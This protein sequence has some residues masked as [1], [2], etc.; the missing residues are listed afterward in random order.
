VGLPAGVYSPIVANVEP[1][2]LRFPDGLSLAMPNLLGLEPGTRLPLYRYGNDIAGWEVVGTASVDATGTRIITDGTLLTAFSYLFAGVQ[3]QATPHTITGRVVEVTSHAVV[4]EDTAAP[5][6][7]EM[8]GVFRSLA[9]EYESVMAPIIREYFGNPMAYDHRLDGDG[10]FVMLFSPAVND[11]SGILAFVWGGDFGARSSC[12]SSD[13]AEIFYGLVPTRSGTDPD[14]LGAVGGWERVMR[15]I[16]IHEVKHIAAF[17]EHRAGGAPRQEDPWLEEATAMVAEELYGREIFGY[18]PRENTTYE[19]GLAC[20]L[21]PD[22][23]GCG[24]APLIMT[25]HFTFLRDYLSAVESRSPLGGGVAF[26]GGG[27]WLLRWALDHAPSGEAQFL[28]ALTRET[29]VYGVENLEARAGRPFREMLAEWSL[30]LEADDDPDLAEPPRPEVTVPSWDVR[31]VFAGLHRDRPGSFP[32]AYPLDPRQQDYGDFL[33][34][35]SGLPGGSASLLELTAPASGGREQ[36]LQI[37]GA[38]GGAPPEE[39]GLSIL[40]LR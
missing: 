22:D 32:T 1:S 37:L 21:N 8:D 7:G 31:S 20:E 12:A 19:R 39:L 15:S 6:A 28:R 10:R 33:V 3:L 23:A 26:L 11:L 29:E 27:W 25:S 34:S 2:G 24:D 13:E 35:V 16:T 40:R 18:G 17:A 4:V 36:L 5:L 30:A 38:D 14:D 9:A